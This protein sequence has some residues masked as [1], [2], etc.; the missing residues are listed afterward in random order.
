[1]QAE[2]DT[3]SILSDW[4]DV[5]CLN[6]LCTPFCGERPEFGLTEFKNVWSLVKVLTLVNFCSW[7]MI[8]KLFE[9]IHLKS[10]FVGKLNG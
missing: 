7:E 5:S 3:S 6:P 2:Y 1:M 8:A 4:P 9:P 10:T